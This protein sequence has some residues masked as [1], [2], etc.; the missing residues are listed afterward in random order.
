MDRD[1]G[2]SRGLPEGEKVIGFSR[3]K[4]GGEIPERLPETEFVDPGVRQGRSC[5]SHAGHKIPAKWVSCVFRSP[6]N[7]PKRSACFF[8]NNA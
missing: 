1:G 7:N 5:W 8:F 4:Q 6:R 2:P 3:S